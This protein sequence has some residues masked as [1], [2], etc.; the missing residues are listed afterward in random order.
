MSVTVYIEGGGDA[1][2]LRTKCRRGF[3]DF[4][5]KA[6]LAGRMPRLIACGARE[7]AYDRFCTALGQSDGAL[8]VLLVDSEGPVADNDGSWKHLTERD[9][10]LKPDQAT[11]DNA[12]LMVQCMEAWFLADKE[13]LAK[14]FGQGFRRNALSMRPEIEAI[15]KV[16]I[17]QGLKNATRQCKHKGQYNKGRHSFAILAQLDPE[18]VTAASPYAKQLID[19]LHEKSA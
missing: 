1:R 5:R 7:K 17:E 14:Y 10:W 8:V 3:S 12:H 6:G 9:N 4:F 19:A 2:E 13:A 16:D 18:K 11:D 15:P